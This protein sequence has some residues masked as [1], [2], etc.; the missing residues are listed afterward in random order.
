M[1]Y[2]NLL[3]F[4]VFLYTTAFIFNIKSFAKVVSCLRGKEFWLVVAWCSLFLAQGQLFSNSLDG[5]GGEISFLGAVYQLV[6]MFIALLVLVFQGVTFSY[7]KDL[8]NSSLLYYLIYAGTGVFTCFLS[9]SPFLSFYK[10][11]QLALVVSILIVFAYHFYI[12]S[13]TL[14][15]SDITIG[16]VSV[17]IYCSALNG[18]FIPDQCFH[19][20][21]GGGFLG[22]TLNSIYPLVQANELGLLSAIVFIV[23]L[24]RV[25]YGFARRSNFF[26]ISS[27]VLSASVMYGAQARTSLFSL[28]LSVFILFYYF[29]KSYRFV[30]IALI[31]VIALFFAEDFIGQFGGSDLAVYLRRGA[32]Q[33][34]LETFSGRTQLWKSGVEMFVDSPFIGHGFQAG[35]RLSGGKFGIPMGLNMHNSYLQILIDSGL[36]GFVPWLMFLVSS[37]L[38]VCRS[39]YNKYN[40]TRF[41]Q[42][43]LE[44]VLIFIIVYFRTFLG[45]VLVVHNFSTMLI[46]AIIFSIYSN[47]YRLKMEDAGWIV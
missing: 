35:V 39:F 41:Y 29:F 33:D 19:F 47:N 46:V 24:S 31:I 15:L 9:V 12:I 32:T 23:S 28:A 36:I 21:Y 22:F 34:Q 45:Q 17:V 3:T 2:T 11:F 38:Y 10:A 26:W 27:C 44:A 4:A 25:F 1:E 43:D 42:Y 40:Y 14:H 37:F 7:S 5:V 18:I 6:W 16:L 13:I 20:L 30:F 8:I